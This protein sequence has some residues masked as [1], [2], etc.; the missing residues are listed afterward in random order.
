VVAD[1]GC[2]SQ[3]LR[4]QVGAFQ[5]DGPDAFHLIERAIDVAGLELDSAAAVDDDV[6]VQSELACIQGTVFDAVIESYSYWA[7]FLQIISEPVDRR[8]VQR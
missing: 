3:R 1:C 7:T 8:W 2:R 5:K 4:L 6:R